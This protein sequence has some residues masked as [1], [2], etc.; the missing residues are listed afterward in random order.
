V[1]SAQE[2]QAYGEA[3]LADQQQAV[4]TASGSCVGDPELIVGSPLQVTG[5]GR[6]DGTYVVEEATHTLNSGGYQTSFQVRS[7]S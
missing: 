3:L 2:A 7:S 5:V 4:I 1:A 6:F